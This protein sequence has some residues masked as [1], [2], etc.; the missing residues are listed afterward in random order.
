MCVSN[1][2]IICLKMHQNAFT[3]GLIYGNIIHSF[4]AFFCCLNLLLLF[5][6]IY[7]NIIH[8]FNVFFCCLNL[9]LLFAAIYGNIIHSF[10]AF[11]CCLNLILLFAAISVSDE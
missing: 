10:N 11:F 7:G 1:V 6:A 9:L 2:L 8:S 5:A 4:N 3:S